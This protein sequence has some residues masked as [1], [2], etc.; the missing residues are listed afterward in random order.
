M[1]PCAVKA[2]TKKFLAALPGDLG[3]NVSDRGQIEQ[4]LLE[5]LE[6]AREAWPQLDLPEDV[7]LAF[8]AGYVTP[9]APLGEQLESLN[10][11]DLYIACG[12]AKG[13]QTAGGLF[14]ERFFPGISAAV[15]KVGALP[16]Q[17]EDIVQDVFKK[18]FLGGKEQEPKIHLYDGVGSLNTW[19][20]VI[21]ANMCID[22]LR[23][24][25]RECTLQEGMLARLADQG[26]G[27]DLAYFKKYYKK[28]FKQA[29]ETALGHLSD[30]ERNVLRYTFLDG[31]TADQVAQIYNVHRV[32]VARWLSKTRR[33]LLQAIRRAL[34][35]EHQLSD[36]EIQSIVRL[37]ETQVSLSME[38]LLNN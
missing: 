9:D 19:L 17:V 23:K 21:A 31:L 38:R 29:F 16:N 2:G 25:G 26:E 10:A 24:R 37:V 32:T 34:R 11:A 7:F 6:A 35:T 5:M 18:I 15:F 8:L 12:C 36:K 33:T 1:E 28:E 30:R 22:M 3:G 14:R 13:D 27:Q 20:K 4:R